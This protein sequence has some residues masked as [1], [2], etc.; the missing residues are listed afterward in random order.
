[1]GLN[2][3]AETFLD[4]IG[5]ST[6]G[7]AVTDTLYVWEN[8]SGVDGKSW[9]RAFTTIQDALDAAST[10][11]NDCTLIL[12]APHSMYYDI[13]AAGDPTWSANVILKGSHRTWAEVVNTNAG[14]T[15]VLKLD[16]KASLMDLCVNLGTSN[17]GAILSY[18]GFRVFGCQFVGE[19]LVS[20][21]TA[22]TLDGAGVL[23]RGKIDNCDFLGHTSYMTAVKLDGV[24]DSRFQRLRIKECNVGVHILDSA[25]DG[26]EFEDVDIGYCTTG[27]NIAAGN[28]QHFKDI[29]LYNNTININ[30]SVGDHIWSGIRGTFPIA[31]TPNDFVGVQVNCGAAGVYG[32]DTELRSAAAATKPFRVL[33]VYLN[34]SAG[35]IYS[36]RLSSDSGSSHYNAMLVEGSA[37]SFTRLTT[38]FLD[39]SDFVFNRG[40]RISASAKSES[41]GNNV[42]VWLNVQEI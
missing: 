37:Q 36:I 26:N 4:E 7:R 35:E 16:G 32:A 22:L 10:D 29:L 13:D 30:D 41:G 27:I 3:P 24:T 6:I 2:N 11:E 31:L 25:S 15:S 33:A 18:N 39:Y 23:D 1:M 12:I 20:A 17:N 34:L 14:A 28:G 40:T 8:G 19:N 42:K 5:A 38:E 21:A 9:N